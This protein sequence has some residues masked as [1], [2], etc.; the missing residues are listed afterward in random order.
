MSNNLRVSFS[1][2]S[3]DCIST[4]YTCIEHGRITSFCHANGM[5]HAGRKS[6]Q[7]SLHIYYAPL[8]VCFLR[9]PFVFYC[10]CR[11]YLFVDKLQ[12][13]NGIRKRCGKGKHMKTVLLQFSFIL[14]LEQLGRIAF[15]SKIIIWHGISHSLHTI[16]CAAEKST[17]F[18][19]A[20]VIMMNIDSRAD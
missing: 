19:G 17:N 16:D 1:V 14:G 2:C 13:K 12:T 8:F 7:N 11:Y 6:N 15:S 18:M 10:V 4:Q 9:N 5:H 3:F 20:I